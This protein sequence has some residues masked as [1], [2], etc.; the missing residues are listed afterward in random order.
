LLT[1]ARK[2]KP[3][4][5]VAKFD[6]RFRSGADVSQT[7]VDSARLGIELVAIA[8][9]LGEEHG[10]RRIEDSRKLGIAI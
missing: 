3:M 2:R 8:K 7:I 9:W 5:M 10:C 1:S 4:I 6:W